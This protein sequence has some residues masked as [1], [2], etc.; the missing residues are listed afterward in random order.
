[1]LKCCNATTPHEF[2]EGIVSELR[3]RAWQ[4]RAA[5]SV[6]GGKRKEA[7]AEHAAVALEN[8]ARDVERMELINQR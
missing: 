7:Q 6:K 2:R 3:H 4:E 5:A 8:L 1:M